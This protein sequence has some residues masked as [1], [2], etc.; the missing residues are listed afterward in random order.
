MQ[1][2][3]RSRDTD[4]GAAVLSPGANRHA[5]AGALLPPGG[6]RH[7]D[8]HAVTHTVAD[9]HCDGHRNAAANHGHADPDRCCGAGGEPDGYGNAG[10]HGHAYADSDGDSSTDGDACCDTYGGPHGHGYAA[11]GHAYGDS[12]VHAI[13]DAHADTGRRHHHGGSGSW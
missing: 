9:A 4:G 11:A 12:G 8:A 1:E 2:R 10:T 5:D 3:R 6:N 13:P 7:A